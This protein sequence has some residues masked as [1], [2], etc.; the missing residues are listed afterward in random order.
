MFL[1]PS[2]PFGTSDGF[3]AQQQTQGSQAQ[4]GIAGVMRRRCRSRPQ[5]AQEAKANPFFSTPLP[6]GTFLPLLFGP[7][8]SR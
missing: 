7:F 4:V 8:C 5:R 1:P 6:Q 3:R 2:E